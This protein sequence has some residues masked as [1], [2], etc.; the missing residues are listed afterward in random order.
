MSLLVTLTTGCSVN[1]Y[2]PTRPGVQWSHTFEAPR[3]VITNLGGEKSLLTLPDG[4]TWEISY[5]PP[6][7]YTDIR[8]KHNSFQG[9]T[10]HTKGDCN[11]K[12]V[13]FLDI[14]HCM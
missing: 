5:Q 4:R 6:G 10:I 9:G 13:T 11:E 2:K 1:D 8:M 3:G 7:Y 14:S 12:E